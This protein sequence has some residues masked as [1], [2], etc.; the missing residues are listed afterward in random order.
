MFYN[1]TNKEL[2]TQ[3]PFSNDPAA[4]ARAYGMTI[5]VNPN[6][7][8]EWAEFTYTLPVNEKTGDIKITDMQGREVY[9]ITV[10]DGQGKIIWDTRSYRSGTYIYTFQS[11][12]HILNG[13]IV[14]TK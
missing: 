4:L 1:L 9:L 14:V 6:P 3:T 8:K 11:G 12:K 7:A 2:Q 13:K 10:S 5:E